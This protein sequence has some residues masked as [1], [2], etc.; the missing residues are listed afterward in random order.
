MGGRG[1]PERAP[2]RHPEPHRGVHDRLKAAGVRVKLDDRDNVNPGFKYNEWEI[3]GVPLRVELGPKDLD[4]DQVVLVKRLGR[5]KSFIPLAEL[6]TQ[7][8]TQLDELQTEMFEAACA[9]RAAATSNVESYDEFKQKLDALGGFLL[10]HWCGNSACEEKIQTETKA[11][12]R[13]LA[14]DQPD[15]TG[16]CMICDSASTK[17]AHFAKAY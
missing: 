8:V 1:R 14:F 7:A 5:A 16:A 12:I 6:E 13:C 9:R 15:E 3:Q 4:K 11:A 2:H 17:R 10:A